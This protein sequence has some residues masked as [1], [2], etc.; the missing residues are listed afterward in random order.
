MEHVRIDEGVPRSRRK[1]KQGPLRRNPETDRVQ[2][3][4]PNLD[5]HHVL[6][7]YLDAN[8]TASVARE[9]G[10]RRSSLLAWIKDKCPEQ[11]RAVQ[12]VRAHIKREDGDS[13]LYDS[14]NSLELS[15]AREVLRSGQ[16]DLER[17]DPSNYGVKQEVAHTFSGPVI[18]IHVVAA[19]Q[20]PIQPSVSTDEQ[21][22]LID[23]D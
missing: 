13:G 15:R 17:L 8:T 6:Q 10:V 2:A 7:L 4:P 3:I 23:S 20:T 1:R 9:L 19:V 18:E 5:P 22:Q 14:T 21:S 16:W 12:L 11:W